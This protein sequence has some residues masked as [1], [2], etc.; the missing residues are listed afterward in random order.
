MIDLESVR[1]RM[2]EAGSDQ[3]YEDPDNYDVGTSK[4]RLDEPPSADTLLTS[5]TTKPSD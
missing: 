2:L 5:S 1:Q 4:K 3:D